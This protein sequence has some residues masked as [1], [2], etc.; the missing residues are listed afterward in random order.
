MER[1]VPQ[2]WFDSQAREAVYFYMS[3]FEDSEMV[4]EQELED[5]PS[6]ENA[7]F[8]DIKLAGQPIGAFNAGPYFILN[9]TISFMVLCDT[10]EEVQ[11]LWDKL[12]DGGKEVMP[13]QAYDFSE[14]YGWV[15]DRFGVSWQLISSEGM[16]YKQKILPALTFSGPVTG[17]AREALTYYTDIFQGGKIGDVYEY[18]EGQA[19]HP[20]A[21]ISHA[22]FEIMDMEIAVADHAEEV[23]DTFNE[24]FSLMVL[25][26][27]QAEID[28]YWEK[29]SA[30]PEAEACGWL[31]DKY[32]VSWQ[33]VPS[34]LSELL[35]T[36]TRK[37]NNAVTQAYLP[38][39]KLYLEKLERAWASAAE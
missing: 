7:S 26:V 24:A 25:C 32:G 4:V 31:K 14:F 23:A 11:V 22:T 21:E 17:K 8:Y 2:L 29:L 33:I 36:G 20:K 37:Q 1:I 27:T 30:D 15:E 10:K 16:E 3:L 28:Y 5:T 13:L 9:R 18:E 19:K 34:N 39:K 38:M 6:G 12:I 35:S